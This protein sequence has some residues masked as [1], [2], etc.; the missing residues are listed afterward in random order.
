[1]LRVHFGGVLRRGADCRDAQKAQE[2][3]DTPHASFSFQR[4]AGGALAAAWCWLSL[5]KG[6]FARESVHAPA[7]YF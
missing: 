7:L 1:V 3:E 5:I 4:W 6:D 2:E